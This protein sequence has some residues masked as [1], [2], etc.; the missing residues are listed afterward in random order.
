[1]GFARLVSTTFLTDHPRWSMQ[2]T[3]TMFSRME[4]TRIPTTA[5][6]RSRRCRCE[7]TPL[8]GQS[9]IPDLSSSESLLEK[10]PSVEEVEEDEDSSFSVECLGEGVV[11]SSII[12]CIMLLWVVRCI[13]KVG[14]ML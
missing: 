9:G 7:P 3:K 11:W 1:M 6:A 5:N 10:R 8:R 2:I 12:G 14:K 4:V 13:G